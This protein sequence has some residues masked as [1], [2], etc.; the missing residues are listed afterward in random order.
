VAVASLTYAAA[1]VVAA[2][3][4]SIGSLSWCCCLLVPQWIAFPSNVNAAPQLPARGT[5]PAPSVYQMVL[6]AP[7]PE[8]RSGESSPRPLLVPAFRLGRRHGRRH[9]NTWFYCS[10][11]RGHGPAWCAGL[12][13]LPSR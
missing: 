8:P 2:L 4:R 6:F 12:T 11:D 5:V 9:G 1:L 10:T 7:R 3:S 13:Q